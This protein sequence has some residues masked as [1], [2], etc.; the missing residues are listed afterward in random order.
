[1]LRIGQNCNCQLKNS[2]RSLRF[3]KSTRRE[4]NC[5]RMRK[6][7]SRGWGAG[8]QRN[9]F[10]PHPLPLLARPLLTSPQFFCSP[11]AKYAMT[12][13]NSK[14]RT[15]K[16][17]IA[18]HVLQKTYDIFISRCCFSEDGKEMYRD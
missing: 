11:Q 5:E 2:L 10:S 15:R 7:K 18:V 1:M 9:S 13:F 16:L 3:G 4:R 17:A 6:I 8:E 14:G 12:T